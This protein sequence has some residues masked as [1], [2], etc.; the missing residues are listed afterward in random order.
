MND[1]HTIV[2]GGNTM[3]NWGSP[4]R[5]DAVQDAAIRE[6][7][8]GYCRCADT[9]DDE[10]MLSLFTHDG[11]WLRPRQEPLRGLDQIG[12]FLRARDRTVIGRHISNN[13]MVEIIGPDKAEVLSYYTVLKATPEGGPVISVMGEYHDSF[14]L[15]HGRWRI[16]RREVRH[17]FRTG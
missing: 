1:R 14:R 15:E 6:V 9:F 13:I 16:A 4:G 3:P 8:V 17:I 7:I 11:E 10:Q 2:D 12:A 5:V